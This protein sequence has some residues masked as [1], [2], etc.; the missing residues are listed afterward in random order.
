MKRFLFCLV[1]MIFTSVVLIGCSQTSQ[2]PITQEPMADTQE[3]AP[4]QESP[5]TTESTPEPTTELTAA[6]AITGEQLSIVATIFPQYDWVYQI[7]GEK[8]DSKEVTLLINNRIDLHNF[9]PSIRDITI[10][11]TCDLFIY[12]GGESDDWV[13]AALEQAINPNM[14]VI[15][16]MDVLG[17]RVLID[18]EIDD[19]HHH[20]HHD[21]DEL[22]EHVWLSLRNAV[23]FTNVIAN[24]LSDLDPELADYYKEN[25]GKYSEQ[26]NNLDLEYA[27]IISSASRDTLLFADR[28]P[29]R[30]LLHDYDLNFYAAF[31]GC[32]AETEASFRTITFLAK[33]LDE[34]GLT[35]V[36]VTESA[37]VSIAE[38]VINNSSDKNQKILILDSMQSSNDDDRV[39]GTTYISIMENNLSVLSD[40]LN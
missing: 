39:Q 25:A 22:D 9:Q 16:L 5:V 8:T 38:T 35:S 14:I 36:I 12:V 18:E 33:R 13:E 34:L 37:N 29:F 10:I 11:S 27:Q 21:E 17:D 7:L 1:V 6:P 32:S 19:G 30:Y 23:I 26:L 20:H 24:A 28:F 40:A 15:K 2:Q 3:S 4:I 31:S